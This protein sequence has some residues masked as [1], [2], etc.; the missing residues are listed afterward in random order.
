[1]KTYTIAYRPYESAQVKRIDV[2]A[3]S[4]YEAYDRATYEV[5]PEVDEGVPYSSW[6]ESVTYKNGKTKTFYNTGEENAF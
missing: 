2:T 4:K 5:I 3:R 1:M 6:V